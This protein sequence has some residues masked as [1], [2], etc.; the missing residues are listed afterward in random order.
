[1]AGPIVLIFHRPAKPDDP[2]LVTL[3]AEARGE[4]VQRQKVMFGAAGAR[5]VRVSAEVAGSFGDLL[6]KSAPARGGVVVLSGGAVPRLQ[7]R[8]AAQLI[9]VAG[10]GAAVA[11][12]NNRYSSDV[13]AIGD[14]SALRPLPPLPSDNSLPRWLEERAGVLVGELRSRERLALDI[15][16]PLDMALWAMVSDAPRWVR[17]FVGQHEMEVPHANNLR[18]LAAD[19]R[20]ELLVFGRVGSSTLRWLE[21][22][23]RCRVRFLSEERGLRASSPLAMG[24]ESPT[25]SARQPRATLGRLMTER[26]PAALGSIVAELADGA[27]LD[28][29][30]LMADQFGPDEAD[31]PAPADRYASDLLRPYD[32][33]DSW[34]RAATA[35]AAGSSIPIA[36]GAHSLVGPGIPLLLPRR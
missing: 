4:L 1:M 32:I 10:S 36:L 3:L 21:R 22:N 20:R 11:L 13:C 29:R 8:D 19:P 16:S 6:I 12:T 7:R 14:V 15:D 34:L 2:T 28:T 30:V 23:V 17:D 27:I 18:A 5:E 35:S 26:G 33:E 24:G 9:E 31:W 25:G